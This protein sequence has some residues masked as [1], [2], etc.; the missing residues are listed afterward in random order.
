MKRNKLSSIRNIVI[1]F[2][3]LFFLSACQDASLKRQFVFFNSSDE[4]LELVIERNDKYEI[5]EKVQ[6]HK[7]LFQVLK[8]GKVKIITF[9]KNNDCLKLRKDYVVEADSNG[10][11]SYTCLDLV[12]NTKYAT[13]ASSYLYGATNSLAQAIS[14]TKSGNGK[15]ILGA[16][17]DG[18]KGFQLNFAPAWPYEPLPKEI[19]ALSAGWVLV[20]I[21]E[22]IDT[23]DKTA[24]YAYIDQ[25]L[26][27]L[28]TKP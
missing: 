26:N 12:G 15:Q 14:D 23:E 19:G 18:D 8:P 7:Q 25:Y 16:I 20:P 13:V 21:S 17:E 6:A 24:L 10:L 9:N 2:G 11:S 1:V 4:E 5:Q 22:K 3:L 27:A 28:G